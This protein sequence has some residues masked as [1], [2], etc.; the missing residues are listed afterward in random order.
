MY[1]QGTG[2]S[3]TEL[4]SGAKALDTSEQR[5]SRGRVRGSTRVHTGPLAAGCRWGRFKGKPV[6]GVGMS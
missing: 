3:T 2:N 5:G 1:M 6:R 4:Q